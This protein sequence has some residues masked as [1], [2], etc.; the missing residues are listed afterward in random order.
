MSSYLKKDLVEMIRMAKKQNKTCLSY[1]NLNK[2]QLYNHAI[3]I[4]LIG[5]EMKDTEDIRKRNL[6]KLKQ[7]AEEMLFNSV[8]GNKKK[9]S[10]LRRADRVLSMKN[11]DITED[12][13]SKLVMDFNK[14]TS[15]G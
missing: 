10:F 13:M 14:L 15:Y 8:I 11:N 6:K 9:S 7:K 4:G 12:I 1:S 5:P 2:N 3:E